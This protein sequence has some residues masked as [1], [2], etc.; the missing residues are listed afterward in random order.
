MAKGMETCGF[1]RDADLCCA[2]GTLTRWF[3]LEDGRRVRFHFGGHERVGPRV[4]HTFRPH[5]PEACAQARLA[6]LLS[7][8]D[9]GELREEL[10]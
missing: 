6:A 1:M 2:C 3:I 5:T 8:R 10:A 9:R 7:L 4:K